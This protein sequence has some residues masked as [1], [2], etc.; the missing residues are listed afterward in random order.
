M[1]WGGADWSQIEY[2]LLVH[3]ASITPGVDVSQALRMYRD[4]PRTDFHALAAEISGKSRS[5]AK[6]INFG[7]MYGM[8]VLKMANSLGVSFNEGKAIL[9]EFHTKSPFLKE[10][11]NTASSR[12]AAR[13]HIKTMMGRRRRFPQWEYDGTI[14]G[15]E[16]AARAIAAER[17]GRGFPRVAMTHKALNALLQGSAADLMKIAMVQ[18]WKAGIFNVL[19]PHLT[20][21]DEM[22]VSVPRTKEGEQAF[23]EMCHIMENCVKL[24]VPVLVDAKRGLNWSE[25]K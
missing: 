18:M 15:S 11:L 1:D 20:V 16:A 21:H 7:V 9:Q 8:G 12:A 19:I 14:Y 24:A 4:D 25:T 3:Y 5:V 6:N 2:R 17:P 13:G 10:M 23:D 22:N